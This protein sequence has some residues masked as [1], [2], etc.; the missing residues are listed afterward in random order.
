VS[1]HEIIQEIKSLPA[2]ERAKIA[3]FLLRED[4]SWIPDDFKAAMKD[5]AAGR[6]LD[7]ETALHETPPPHLR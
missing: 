1:A 7:T 6:L 5:M 3:T 2:I 4:D